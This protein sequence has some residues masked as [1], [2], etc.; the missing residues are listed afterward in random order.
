MHEITWN[1]IRGPVTGNVTGETEDGY[2]IADVG[3]GKAVLVHPKSVIKNE[4]R[5]PS[6][7][8]WAA[9]KAEHEREIAEE[10]LLRQLAESEAEERAMD[11]YY[12]DKYG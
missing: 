3:D 8:D 2:L 11:G 5:P 4:W 1:G 12:R 10:E 6:C 7:V 9:C